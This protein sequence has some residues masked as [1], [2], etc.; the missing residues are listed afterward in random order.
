MT[1]DLPGLQAQNL[2]GEWLDVLP[3]K[4]TLV[5]NFGKGQCCYGA[6]Q[7]LGPVITSLVLT[8]CATALETVTRGVVLATSHRVVSPPIG[9]PARY[10]IPFF[11]LISQEIR[12]GDML[13]DRKL[14][15]PCRRRTRWM[16][17]E[18]PLS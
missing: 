1:E 3:K 12:L 9:S 13:I 4:G 7:E 16:I 8:S 10:S 2:A 17:D 15:V 5:V 18:L 11:Q 6:V 14:I